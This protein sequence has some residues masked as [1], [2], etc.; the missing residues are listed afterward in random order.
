M[1]SSNVNVMTKTRIK[2]KPVNWE[3]RRR[4]EMKNSRRI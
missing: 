2:G 3:E 1:T 4:G